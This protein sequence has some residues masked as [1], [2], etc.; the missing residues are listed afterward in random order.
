M[1]IE[2]VTH[3]DRVDG[4]PVGTAVPPSTAFEFLEGDLRDRGF[5][6]PGVWGVV[7]AAGIRIATFDGDAP[8]GE[9]FQPAPEWGDYRTL[10]DLVVGLEGTV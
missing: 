7:R 4:L 3:T 10:L 8:A 9:R 5:L 6:R 1:R 2:Y